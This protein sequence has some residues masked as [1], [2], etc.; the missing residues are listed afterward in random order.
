MSEAAGDL[1]LVPKKDRI[2]GEGTT[3]IMA[4]FTHLNPEGSR[5]TDGSYGV[6]YAA[7]D[8]DTAIEETKF[9][10]ARFLAATNE[11]PIHVD[12]RSY[13]SNISVN[14]D[15][16]RGMKTSF[17][18]IYASSTDEYNHPQAFAK[19]LRGSGSNG[20]VYD[21]VRHK[22]GECV[23]IFK[24]IVLSPVK[25]GKHYCYVWDGSK[26][27]DMYIKTKHQS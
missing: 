3:P 22:I 19:K 7:K 17:P 9:H 10:K 20:I 24:P 11:P 21:S 4:A 13:S 23:A 16:I 12:M 26:I 1:S 27:T 8:I 15:D 6:Y 14:L 2:A 25:Q 5:F 18:E